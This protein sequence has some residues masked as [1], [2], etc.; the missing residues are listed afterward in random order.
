MK[1]QDFLGEFN[2]L[3]GLSSKEAAKHVRLERLW[4]GHFLYMRWVWALLV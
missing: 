2:E 1:R 4:G 3:A